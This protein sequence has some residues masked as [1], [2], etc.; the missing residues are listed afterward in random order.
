MA[1]YSVRHVLVLALAMLAFNAHALSPS[2]IF[3]KVKDSVVVVKALDVT[4]RTITQGSGVLL[5]SGKIGT[6]C[7]VVKN[8]VS[9]QAGG[10][11]HFVPATLWGSNEDKDICLLDAAGLKAEP[12]QLGQAIH[13]K[14]GEPVYAVGAPRG[15]E[16]SISDGIV[17]QLR[18]TPPPLIQTTTAISPGSSGGG[19]F[20]AEGLLVGFTTLYI[21]GAQSLNFAT[22]VEWAEKIQPVN[23][24]VQGSRDY[25]WTDRNSALIIAGDWIGS[26]DLCKQWTQSQPRNGK[27]WS[28]LGV[29]Y[30][31]LE[32]YAKAM[33]AYRKAVR[34]DPEDH[35]TW[36]VLG[37]TYINLKRY[38]E[39]IDAY[40]QVVRIIPKEPGAWNRIGFVYD[41]LKRYP[42]AL[43]A[44]RAAIRL[45]PKN[46]EAWESIGSIFML[47]H[48][49]NEAIDSLRESVRLNPKGADALNFLGLTY[50]MSG[51][52][53]AALEVMSQL[54]Q[55]DSAKADKLALL[56][57][58]SALENRGA[59]DGWVLVGSDKIDATYA[60]PSTIR[61]NGPM[62]RM[63]DLVDF[64]KTQS[65]QNLVKPYKS[66]RGQSEY[67]C[68][69]ERIRFLG[70]SLHSE[71]MARGN[72]VFSDDETGKWIAAPPD[73]RGRRLW[74]VACGKP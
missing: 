3:E 42:E 21:K 60:N 38:T 40:K 23:K 45:D 15:L 65:G 16:L 28:H 1:R 57:N 48:R 25:D 13:L 52:R 50:L 22:P 66:I 18:G 59:E 39:A 71:N 53:A 41:T 55:I 74:S 47:L 35:Y 70:G 61:G 20:D 5:P 12:A 63:W 34:I 44:F 30:M 27:A 14:V 43:D 46:A 4:G 6:N 33:D 51:N 2:Q 69:G 72:V 54:R 7:H 49:Y 11:K 68:E 17:S 58:G 24:A 64:K 62:V 56:V 29:A 8:G 19:L 26:R 37:S 32:S 10:G 9:F 31:M 73:S 36:Y 67:D